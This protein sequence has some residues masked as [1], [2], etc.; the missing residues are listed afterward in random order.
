MLKYTPLRFRH[1][2]W[3]IWVPVLWSTCPATCC[4]GLPSSKDTGIGGCVCWRSKATKQVLRSGSCIQFSH[5]PTEPKSANMHS[6]TGTVYSQK[7]DR[8]SHKLTPKRQN[9]KA[10]PHTKHNSVTVIPLIKHHENKRKTNVWINTSK[11]LE[12]IRLKERRMDSSVDLYMHAC[13]ITASKKK[14]PFNQ[15]AFLNLYSTV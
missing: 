5:S 4:I 2:F 10:F 1:C 6:N 7:K 15:K 8:R 9:C 3:S 13:S 14:G 12:C 11:P